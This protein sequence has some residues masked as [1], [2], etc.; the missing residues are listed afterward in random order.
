METIAAYI[1]VTIFGYLIPEILSSISPSGV[2]F[3]IETN[4][5]TTIGAIAGYFA[6]LG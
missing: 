2:T 1:A 4:I 3:S 5:L 6:F